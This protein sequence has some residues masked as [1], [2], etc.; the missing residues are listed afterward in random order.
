MSNF[1]YKYEQY[2]NASEDDISR[3]AEDILER[4]SS[5]PCDVCQKCPGG[6]QT[7][8][9]KLSKKLRDVLSN[10]SVRA[11]DLDYFGG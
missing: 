7:R 5:F 11:D 9:C 6:V 4:I 10:I 8:N 2:E 3:D 1:N